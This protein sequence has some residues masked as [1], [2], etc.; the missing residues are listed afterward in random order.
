MSPPAPRREA[1][2]HAGHGV[3]HVDVSGAAYLTGET[4]STD[5]PLLRAFQ[6]SNLGVVGNAIVAAV[7]A[8]QCRILL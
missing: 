8:T 4:A 6:T 7:D 1:V 2:S 5:F 3:F